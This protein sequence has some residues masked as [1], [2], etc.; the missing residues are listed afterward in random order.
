M[1]KI[2]LNN[3]TTGETVVVDN[4]LIFEDGRIYI[5]EYPVKDGAQTDFTRYKDVTEQVAKA[6]AP[7]LERKEK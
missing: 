7:Y 3:C 4:R 1:E 5:S 2:E 6:I